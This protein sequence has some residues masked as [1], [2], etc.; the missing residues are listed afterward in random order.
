VRLPAQRVCVRRRSDDF[1]RVPLLARP[2]VRSTGD[3]S[4]PTQ[5][6]AAVAKFRAT[7]VIARGAGSVSARR[8]CA[9]RSQPT[10]EQ[11]TTATPQGSV[12]SPSDH[13]PRCSVIA[14]R[15]D[16]PNSPSASALV[17]SVAAG[18]FYLQVTHHRS[19]R[20][21][22]LSVPGFPREHI[23]REISPRPHRINQ[24]IEVRLAVLC[25]ES[26]RGYRQNFA[27]NSWDPSHPTCQLQQ[28]PSILSDRPGVF[29]LIHS[30]V[31]A[32]SLAKRV[33]EGSL[34]SWAPS[35]PAGF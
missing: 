27:K 12:R 18:R 29:A 20:A 6:R 2:A 35:S 31:R 7:T 9:S 5:G 26:D 25:Q 16:R 11:S 17:S 32:N 13:P 21:H 33:G 30:V 15:A 22:A 4:N 14:I 24:V 23:P 19:T 8:W 28:K 10:R 3:G 34:S 1:R